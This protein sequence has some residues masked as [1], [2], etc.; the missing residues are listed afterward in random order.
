MI[1]KKQADLQSDMGFPMGYGD[2]AV[3]NCCLSIV[4]EVGEVLQEINWKPWRKK[5]VKVNNWRVLREL[6]DILQFWANAV[7]A[8][9]YSHDDVKKA[10]EEKWEINS[11]RAKA[12]Y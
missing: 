8:M 11:R 9:G 7:T 4:S 2:E 1:L 6:N 10:L 3:K 5:K 12:G